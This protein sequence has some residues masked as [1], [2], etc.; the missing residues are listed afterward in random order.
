MTTFDIIIVGAG[1]A[2]SV[3]AG[4]LSD[5]PKL[6]V[7]LLEAGPSDRRLWIR[8]P[9]GYGKTFFDPAVNWKYTA[10][11]DPGLAGRTS[12]MPRGK[13]LGGSSSINAMVYCRGMPAD[14]DDWR[15]AGNPGWGWSDVEPWFRKVERLARGDGTA[16]GDGP[17]WVSDR[18]ADYHRLSRHFV[19]TVREAGLP[20]VAGFDGLSAEGVGPYLINT[21]SGLR[22]SA[23][24]AFLR[25]AIGRDNLEVR[26]GAL[27]ERILFEGKR[28]VGVLVRH[29]GKTQQISARAEVIL[30]AGAINSP[31]L[32]QLSG[33][34]P[35]EVLA[36]AG[37]AVVHDSAGVGRNL[38][39]HLG[40]NYYYRASEPTLNQQL[41]TFAGQIGCGLQY[42]FGR[43]GPLSLSI[44]QFGGMV[45]SSPDLARPDTQLYLNPLSYSVS[46]ADKR[47]LLQP[48]RWPGFILS[49]NSCRPTSRGEVAIASAD[50]AAPPRITPRYLS[51]AKDLADV[52]AG[53]RLIS[54][55][56]R[57]PAMQR[58]I[59]RKPDLDLASMSDAE[60]IADFRQR[61]GTVYHQSCSCRMAPA[62]DGGVVGTD[63]KVHGLDGLRVVDASVFPNLTS[64][65]TN[66]PTI[67]LAAKAAAAVATALK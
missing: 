56:D 31:Q 64:A 54:R 21:R 30:A 32:L 7:L 1:S 14:Y 61:S 53:A 19:A 42:I 2:G 62:A 55:L 51:T 60:I 24:D 16:E 37:V 49:F 23:A 33:I 15:D 22:C 18:A 36:K 57:T 8:L 20:G 41:G 9:I 26:T 4:K 66:A 6:R 38:Q 17:L 39:D 5:N 12:Y 52:V 40:I 34:G 45:R 50:P 59:A 27:V 63:L 48:D 43:K 35:G 13:V 47:P 11:A 29:G 58:L 3:L 44:N 67:M 10:E 28:A 46:Y 25:P 65:N